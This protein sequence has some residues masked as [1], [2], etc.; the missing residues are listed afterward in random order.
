M[1]GPYIL[2]LAGKV[3]APPPVG[4]APDGVVPALGALLVGSV[5]A[6]HSSPVR[7]DARAATP[8]PFRP[9]HTV[10]FWI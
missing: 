6:I 1:V 4:L 8:G 7:P 3:Y 10:N 9:Q 2:G 5:T